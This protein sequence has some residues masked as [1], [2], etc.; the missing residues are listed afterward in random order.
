MLK[1]ASN[2]HHLRK[3]AH[4]LYNALGRFQNRHTWQHWIWP[5]T[6][7]ILAMSRP[8]VQMCLVTSRILTN[9][10]KITCSCSFLHRV[11]HTCSCS[12]LHTV[13]HTSVP[14]TST[15]THM[16]TYTIFQHSFVHQLTD[17]ELIAQVAM[18]T[19]TVIFFKGVLDK[20]I[21]HFH[22]FLVL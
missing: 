5:W 16:H 21:L 14:T 22:S 6:V 8:S 12:F 11:K 15:Y 7:C 20:E 3:S 18:T 17:T 10:L 9:S 1:N 2:R 4:K 13:K 19:P